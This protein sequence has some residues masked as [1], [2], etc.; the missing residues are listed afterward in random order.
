MA[1]Y[2][3]SNWNL[4]DPQVQTWEQAQVAVLMDIRDELKMLNTLLHCHNFTGM[5]A[6]LRRIDR[7]LMSAGAKVKGGRKEKS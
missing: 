2:K 6:I 3:D 4:P 1:R 5:P 7:R